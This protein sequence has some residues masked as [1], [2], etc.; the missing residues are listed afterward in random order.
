MRD[1][2]A[3]TDQ[4]DRIPNRIQ[5]GLTERVLQL[6]L[7]QNTIPPRQIHTHPHQTQ[8]RKSTWH[9]MRFTR[10]LLQ[11]STTHS[12]PPQPDRQHQSVRRDTILRKYRECTD[13]TT[14][15][16]NPTHYIPCRIGKRPRRQDQTTTTWHTFRNTKN[17]SHCTLKTVHPSLCKRPTPLQLRR[18]STRRL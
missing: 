12:A 9:T 1:L 18:W 15:S 11:A 6:S 2:R 3:K 8:Q 5:K 16:R 17:Y 10:H 4:I 7:P 14:H 13:T